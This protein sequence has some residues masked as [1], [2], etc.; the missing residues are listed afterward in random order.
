[1]SRIDPYW[2]EYPGYK[3]LGRY[4]P[5]DARRI[6]KRLEEAHIPFK[7]DAPREVT[8]LP[9]FWIT[10]PHYLYIYVRAEYLNEANTIV[11]QSD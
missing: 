11:R 9:R 5:K 1:M 10:T 2:T 7:V 3:A 4:E 8:P 6:L